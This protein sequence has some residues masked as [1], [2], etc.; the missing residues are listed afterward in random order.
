MVEG[1]SETFIKGVIEPS[2]MIGTHNG[3]PICVVGEK[4]KLASFD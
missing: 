4:D 1:T 3:A 2:G